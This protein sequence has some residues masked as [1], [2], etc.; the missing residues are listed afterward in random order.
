MK[1]TAVKISRNKW[2]VLFC[3]G[4]LVC[5]LLCILLYV[6]YTGLQPDKQCLTTHETT[7]KPPKQLKT[8][9]DYF[10]LGN[11]NY[12]R[13][14]CN[15]AVLN[16]SLAITFDPKFDRAYNNRAYTYMR[17]QNYPPALADLNQA[18]AINPNYIQALMNRGDIYNYY[19][20]IDRKKAL[21]DYDKIL[22]L[23]YD[24]EKNETLCGHRLLAKTNGWTLSTLVALM[25]HGPDSGCE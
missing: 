20:H 2:L 23:R 3:L 14:Q 4:A 16:Y 6:V 8:A 21:K 12:D 18:I 22:S 13:G 1:Q 25:T 11:Y 9:Q 7:T 5:S 17:M 10:D 19:Y 15:Q 24:T